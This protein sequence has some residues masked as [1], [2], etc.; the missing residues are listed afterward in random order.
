MALGTRTRAISVGLIAILLLALVGIT[1]VRADDEP[2]L[3]PASPERLV[4]SVTAALSHPLTISGEVETHIDLGLPG[5]PASLSGEG[6]PIAM[7]GGSQRFRVWHAP[8]GLRVAHLLDVSEQDLVVN[9]G[10]AWWWDAADL[11]ATRISFDAARTP[12]VAW[13][14][15]G[16]SG[17]AAAAADPLALSRAALDQLAPFATV[18]VNGTAR[19]AGR[20]AYVLTLTPTSTLTLVG[21]I[22]VAVDAE[23]RVPLRLQ[24]FPRDAG[25]AAFE[26]G[27][28]SVSYDP[29]DP[30][31]FEFTPPPGATVVNGTD[32]ATDR[33]DTR[34]GA[35]D[36]PLD[37]LRHASG[38]GAIRTFGRGFDTRVAVPLEGAMPADLAQL[39]PYAGPLVSA[40]VVHASDA[41]WLLVGSV[42]VDV[43]ERDAERLS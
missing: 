20:D 22:A 25:D 13:L 34:D 2:A 38:G 10:E 6:G 41:T 18:A 9:R 33:L 31:I 15:T 24:V 5:V 16:G 3:P 36:P 42:P 23:A 17:A 21:R 28:S 35:G 11:T 4:A 40:V 19:V 32:R 7:V 26:V 39:L 43:L 27:F 29:I 14:G 30:A 8:D 1:V 12:W 37:A